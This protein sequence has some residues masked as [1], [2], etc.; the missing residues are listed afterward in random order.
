ME[1]RAFLFFLPMIALTPRMVVKTFIDL[2][3]QSSILVESCGL[4]IIT[5]ADIVARELELVGKKKFSGE[6]IIRPMRI[7]LNL[8]VK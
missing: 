4:S 7:P 8:K 3:S 2:G 5:E 1:R 6:V